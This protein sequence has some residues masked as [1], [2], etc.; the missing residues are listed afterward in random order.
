M[1]KT[2]LEVAPMKKNKKHRWWND[3][4]EQSI[5]ERLKTWKKWHSTK[6]NS[7]WEAFKKQR[8]TTAKVI[9]TTKRN[10]EKNQ[11]VQ[12][13]EDF[14]RNNTRSFY[15]TF[16][17]K[18]QKYESPNLCFK[19]EEGKLALNNEDNCEILAKYFEKLL[20]CEEPKNKFPRVIPSLRNP[21]SDPP[22]VEEINLII[23]NLKNN[24]AP[25]EDAIIA[26]LWKN[27]GRNAVEKLQRLLVN[28]WIWNREELPEDWKAA[29]IHPIFKKGDKTDANNYRGISLL[30]VTYK[31]LSK[32]LQ[33]R[34]EDQLDQEIGEYQGGFRKGR[35]CVEQILNLKFVIRYRKVR[36]KDTFITFVDFKKAYD[37]I[38]RETLF[39]VLEEF[40]ADEKTVTIIR[41]TLT[42]TES[43]VKFAG[44]VS[45]SFNVQTGVRQGDWLSPLLF[46]C[47]LE[48][49][50]REWRRRTEEEGIQKIKI[51]RKN[52]NLEIDCL[53]FADDLAILSDNIEDATKQINILKEVSGRKN[54]STNFI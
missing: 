36:S 14:R 47:V 53:A 37:S 35:S 23:K 40:G 33:N 48:K 39:N 54:R 12:L 41:Q 8:A 43:K 49:V 22:T 42:N 29:L 30:P 1:V 50:I 32:A 2:A 38:D 7:E 52:E 24:K 26:E 6:D 13:D 21:D 27:S 25:G 28:V 16:K 5:Q 20:N 31:I 15:S 34:L 44:E 10:F 45:R 9:R 11:L 19:N 3:E 18:L 51:G 4:C 17:E 46:N